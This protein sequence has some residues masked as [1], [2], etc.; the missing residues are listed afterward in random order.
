MGPVDGLTTA[1]HK[2]PSMTSVPVN[3]L[4]FFRQHVPPGAVVTWEGAIE[5][6]RDGTSSTAFCPLIE[7]GAITVKAHIRRSGS[8]RTTSSSMVLRVEDVRAEDV[9]VSAIDMAVGDVLIDESLPQDVIN[10]KTMQY[11]FDSESIASLEDLGDGAYRT[12]MSRTVM[13]SVTTEPPG[14]GP[15]VEWTVDGAVAGIGRGQIASFDTIGTHTIGAGAL[16]GGPSV[17]VETY[18]VTITSHVS[19][20]DMIAQGEPVTFEAVTNPPGHEE[21][22]RW[23]A[24]TQFGF[25]DPIRGQGP[26]FTVQFDDTFEWVEGIGDWQW[27]GVKADDVVYNQDTKLCPLEDPLCGPLQPV[28]CPTDDPTNEICVLDR[29]IIAGGEAVPVKCKCDVPGSCGPL[30]VDGDA[31]LCLGECPDPDDLCQIFVNGE[32]TGQRMTT[33]GELDEGD[34]VSCGCDED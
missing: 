30:Q 4:L 33:I 27:L 12:S 31:L 17:A 10:L 14:F 32:P 18:G 20:A 34:V 11:Y 21:D 2:A 15:L 6:D 8:G 3:T 16:A 28:D 7:T 23:L 25:S 9:T 13:A 5:T 29:V 19:G 24:S 22:I 26:A 1:W